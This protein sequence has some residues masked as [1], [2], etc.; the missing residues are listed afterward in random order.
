[1]E[2]SRVNRVA[3]VCKRATVNKSRFLPYLQ[4]ETNVSQFPVK[5]GV[6]AGAHPDCV[7]LVSQSLYRLM[8]QKFPGEDTQQSDRSSKYHA[9][10][11]KDVGR[12]W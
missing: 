3:D 4:H 8:C 5:G 6:L 10:D 7:E 12:W 9:V 2:S 1:M 11:S